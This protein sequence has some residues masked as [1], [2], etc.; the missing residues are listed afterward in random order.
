MQ[1]SLQ[2]LC[3]APEDGMKLGAANRMQIGGIFKGIQGSA[4]L[5]ATAIGSPHR[6]KRIKGHIIKMINDR[7]SGCILYDVLISPILFAGSKEE[8]FVRSACDQDSGEAG[9]QNNI[10]KMYTCVNLT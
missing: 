4:I 9:V 8:M 5:I 6:F 10:P 1:V 7:A 2:A 3:S